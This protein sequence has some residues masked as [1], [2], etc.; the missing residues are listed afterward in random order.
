MKPSTV[1]G[2]PYWGNVPTGPVCP[3]CSK[4]S[5]HVPHVNGVPP[6]MAETY[7]RVQREIDATP[8]IYLCEWCNQYLCFEMP[9]EDWSVFRPVKILERPSKKA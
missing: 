4:P 9:A 2:S 1:A 6:E 5:W 8:P 3:D 7:A